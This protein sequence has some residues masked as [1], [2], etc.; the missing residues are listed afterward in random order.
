MTSPVVDIWVVCPEC[1]QRYQDWYRPSI[2]LTL[3]SFDEEYLREATTSK[4]PECGYVVEH[5]ALVVGPDGVWRFRGG[6]GDAAG[7]RAGKK[8]GRKKEGKRPG[9]NRPRRHG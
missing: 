2:N 7:K 6:T 3:D 8:A 1:G 9:S 5:A 4:C